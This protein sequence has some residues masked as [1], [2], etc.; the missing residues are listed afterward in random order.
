MA[1]VHLPLNVSQGE[2]LELSQEYQIGFTYPVFVLT[3][4]NGKVINQWIGYTGGA[5]ALIR[6]LKWALQDLSTIDQR[7]DRFETSPTYKEGL[8]LAGHFSKIGQHLKSIEYYRKSVGLGKSTFNDY[9]YEIFSNMANA[10]WKDMIPLDSLFPTADAVLNSKSGKAD[11]EYKVAQL[12]T[13]VARKV[14][15]TDEIDPY[16]QAGMKAALGPNENK[17]DPKYRE[18]LADYILYIE[19][20]LSRAT[21]VKKISMGQGWKDD[22]DKFYDYSKWCLEREINLEEAEMYARKAINLVFPGMYRARVLNTVAD[23]CY[24]RDKTDEAV[25]FINLAIDEDPDNRLYQNQLKR[26]LEGE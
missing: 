1:V 16:L 25:K 8:F 23:I 2:G 20:N 9:S 5:N 3:N 15:R 22:R 17:K 13:R 10:V 21:K 6:T 4:S 18:L 24:A 26:Y 19:E 12:I 7:I 14:G 11:K